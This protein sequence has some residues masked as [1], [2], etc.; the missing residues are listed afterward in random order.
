[1]F[2][3]APESERLDDGGGR[4]SEYHDRGGFLLYVSTDGGELLGLGVDVTSASVEG[5]AIETE[6]GVHEA[7]FGVVAVDAHNWTAVIAFG[8]NGASGA[9]QSISAPIATGDSSG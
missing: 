8:G 7:H 9:V 6:H 4:F 1:M 3:R 2:G 5:V